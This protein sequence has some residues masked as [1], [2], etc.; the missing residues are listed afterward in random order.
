MSNSLIVIFKFSIVLS[1]IIG[2][3]RYGK[4]S[5]TYHPF[6]IIMLAAFLAEI[7]STITSLL[8]KSDALSSNVYVIIECFLWLWQ[9]KRWGAGFERAWMSSVMTGALVSIWVIES[10]VTGLIH[11]NTVFVIVYSF[12]LVLLAINQVN[13]L[14]V[15]EKTNLLK[16]AKFLICSGMIIFYTYSVLVNSFYV[17]DI[18]S[19]RF[20]SNIY[21]IL[22][23]V[24]LFVNLLYAI[25]ILWIPRR[26]R[27]TLLS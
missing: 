22:I 18:E 7:S 19:V 10:I 20:L 11:F 2:L 27:F 4:I 8:Y 16:N 6:I 9:F 17:L 21:Y 13:K 3:V 1:L 12:L 14:I 5:R 23:Y 25:A 26:E 15:Q 24:N